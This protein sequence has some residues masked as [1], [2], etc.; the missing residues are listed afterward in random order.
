MRTKL[1]ESETIVMV[2]KR[3]PVTIIWLYATTIALLVLRLWLPTTSLRSVGPYV[4]YIIIAVVLV[5]IVKTWSRERDIWVVTD[6]RVVDEAGIFTIRSMECP[7]DKITNVMIAQSVPGRILGYGKIQIQT[8]GE[9]GLNE[10]VKV[11]RPRLFRNAIFE[12][13][14]RSRERMMQRRA[15]MEAQQPAEE[16]DMKECPFC[17]EKIRAKAVICRFCNRELPP[18]Q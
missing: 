6:Q 2:T 12:Q 16:E 18:K 8:A 3:H 13:Q 11:M 10:V 14:E 4:W 7:L 5:S 1:R 9:A 17:A 15:E